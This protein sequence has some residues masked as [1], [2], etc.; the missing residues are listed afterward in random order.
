[1]KTITYYYEDR[2]SDGPLRGTHEIVSLR[3][4]DVLGFVNAV[5]VEDGVIVNLQAR[6]VFLGIVN[7]VE[8][9]KEQS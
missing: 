3:P 6:R 8:E 1:M 9:P 7:I 4:S 2:T 5:R